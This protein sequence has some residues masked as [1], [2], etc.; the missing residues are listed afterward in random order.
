MGL[1]SYKM[2]DF[3]N[4]QLLRLVKISAA[5]LKVRLIDI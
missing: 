2:S 4:F 1:L 3:H 5:Q